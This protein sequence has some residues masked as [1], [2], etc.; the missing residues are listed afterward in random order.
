MATKMNYKLIDFGLST[1]VSM[2]KPL[3]FGSDHYRSPS[4]ILSMDT[5]ATKNDI[6]S[7]GV[8]LYALFTSRMPFEPLLVHETE[9]LRS[10]SIM[11]RVA[12]GMYTFTQPEE[13]RIGPMGL[14]FLK[15]L[16]NRDEDQRWTAQQGLDHEWLHSV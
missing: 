1:K 3:Q 8:I 13:D 5:S 4:S 16:L 12:G 2:P 10:R 7:V 11:R 14:L 9:S 15:G 6:W